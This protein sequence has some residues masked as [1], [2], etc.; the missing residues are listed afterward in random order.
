MSDLSSDPFSEALRDDDRI[1]AA[2]ARGVR[3]AVSE[4]KRLGYAIPSWDWKEEKVFWIQ[5]EDI[6]EF[7]DPEAK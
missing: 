2:M 4:H 5:P 7:P 1:T 3:K 6:P